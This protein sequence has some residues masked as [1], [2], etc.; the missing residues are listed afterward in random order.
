MRLLSFRWPKQPISG[1]PSTGSARMEG[2]GQAGCGIGHTGPAKPA[3]RARSST[4]AEWTTR[5]VAAASTSPARGNAS[6]RV[7]QSGGTRLSMTP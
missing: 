7:S 5:P 3:A 1:L 2:S 6:A 4:N